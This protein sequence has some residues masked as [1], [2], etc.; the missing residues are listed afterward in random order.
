VSVLMIVTSI[1]MILGK[2]PPNPIYGFRT[3]KTLS[4]PEIWY[5]VNAYAGKLT[6]IWGVVMAAAVFVLERI[7]GMGVEFYANA[8]LALVLGIGAV[9]M[10]LSFNHLRKL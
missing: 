6:F 7:Q 2:V 10:I 3:R 4:D 8:F 1:P 9:V 5:D